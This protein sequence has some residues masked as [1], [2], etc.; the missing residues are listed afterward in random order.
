MDYSDGKDLSNVGLGAM[1]PDLGKLG[2]VAKWYDVH[3]FEDAADCDEYREH[4]ERGYQALLGRVEATASHV[5][6]HH[7]Q[8]FDGGG[9]PPPKPRRS[10]GT[11][12]P[13]AGNRIHV[14][15]R[16]VAVANTIDGLMSVYQKRGL[17]LVAALSS[18]QQQPF[19]GMFDPVILDATLRVLPPFPLGAYVDLSD[20]RQ[21]VVSD[22]DVS[23]PC[24]PKVSLLEST[25]DGGTF[26]DLD[27]AAPGMP[28]IARIGDRPVNS[29]YLYSLSQKPPVTR[30]GYPGFR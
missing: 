12:E 15:S 17:P 1:L 14:F 20:G 28:A 13:I 25:N 27:L 5:A 9:F 4:A 29:E 21:A 8:R 23:K 30:H 22:L 7:H 3:F 10:P 26:D 18:V 24:Q 11:I 19:R 16:L 6:W 2:M